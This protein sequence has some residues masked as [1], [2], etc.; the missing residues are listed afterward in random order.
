MLLILVLHLVVFLFLFTLMRVS[1]K[2]LS[3]K[4]QASHN[5][6][7][8]TCTI[9]SQLM[10]SKTLSLSKFLIFYFPSS[11]EYLGLKNP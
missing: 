1:L 9:D 11:T 5:F 4:S 2:S 3:Q 6:S 7:Y 10:Q 8:Q